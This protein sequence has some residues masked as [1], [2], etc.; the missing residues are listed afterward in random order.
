[1]GV[2]MLSDK[3]IADG[4][5]KRFEYLT[6]I[7][8][9]IGDETRREGLKKLIADFGVRFCMSPASAKLSHH[10]AYYGG[11]YDHSIEVMKS[12]KILCDNYAQD[13]YSR[14]SIIT[15]AMFHDL[16]KIGDDTEDYWVE[17]QSEWHVKKLG[18]I[19]EKNPKCIHVYHSIR[20]VQYLERYGVVLTPEETQAIVYHDGQYV[21]LGEDVKHQETTLCVLLH[22][23][24]ALQVHLEK[25]KIKE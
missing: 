18:Q 5:E 2:Y 20:S 4:V 11:L 16:G 24:D 7:V 1:M 6:K 25:F 19:Y 10:H 13:K 17:N 3:A 8:D 15:I 21:P 12:L 14:D 23:A 9:S 22:F